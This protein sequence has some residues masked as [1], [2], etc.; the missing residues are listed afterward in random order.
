M[1]MAMRRKSSRSSG[2]RR[3]VLRQPPPAPRRGHGGTRATSPPAE[4]VST[5]VPRPI[6]DP[7][8]IEGIEL[9]NH[10]QFFAAHDTLE[11]LWLETHDASRRF[12]QG[13]IQAA[14]A[15]HHWS[16]GNLPGAVSLYRS[17]RDRLRPYE[18]EHLGV[19]VAQFLRHYT[20]LFNWVRRHPARYD[21]RLV[22]AIRWSRPPRVM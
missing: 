4:S 3:A 8:L 15:F 10:R 19:D 14:V 5:T 12:Y 13:L 18:P 17:S 2:G 6:V 22:P 9:F 20:E 11:R 16:Q 7:R 21:A 1:S